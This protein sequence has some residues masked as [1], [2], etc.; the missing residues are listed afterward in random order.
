MT[1]SREEI[2]EWGLW[3]GFDSITLSEMGAVK[4]MNRIDTK[5]LLPM[6]R[7]K[8][9]LEMASKEYRVQVV[10]DKRVASYDSIYFDTVNL[11]MF[12]R[13]HDRQ[14]R[15]NKVRTRKYI[16]S[17]LC[18]LEIKC[19]NNKGRTKKKRI[20]ID[21]GFFEKFQT[22]MEAVEFLKGI[23]EYKAADLIPQLHTQF[24]RITL[25][26]KAKTERLTID[27]N[28]TFVNV[29]NGIVK[30]LGPLAVIELKQDGLVHSKMKDML[31]SMRVHPYKISKYCIGVSLTN[32]NAKANRFKKKLIHIK[33]LTE[34]QEGCKT[35]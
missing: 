3:S 28:L 29:Q 16:D 32:P 21:G 2:E 11:E 22:S 20:Q 13:H 15:R 33:K 8:Q 14:L 23:V 25:V 31:I 34:L 26:D 24:N 7:L 30:E 5:F 18:F 6:N 12:T 19:K 1:I 4:L 35:L 27:I 10:E 9:L 17:D